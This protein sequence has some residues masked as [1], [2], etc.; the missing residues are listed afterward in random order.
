MDLA[1]RQNA[2]LSA[3]LA[4]DAISSIVQWGMSEVIGPVAANRAE[5]TLGLRCG[6]VGHGTA[7]DRCIGLGTLQ[8]QSQ[9]GFFEKQTAKTFG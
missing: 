6:K 8:R 5:E 1:N 3:N 7:D 2:A 9:Y 4:P